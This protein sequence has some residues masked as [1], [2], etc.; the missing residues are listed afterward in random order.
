MLLRREQVHKVV[1]NQLISTALDLQ[2]L[3]TSDKAW[4]WF[5]YNYTDDETSLEK[6][7]VR[8]K[9]CE[10]A[11]QFYEAVQTAIRAVKDNQVSKC[12]PSTLEDCGIEN[13]SSDETQPVVHEVDDEQDDDEEEDDDDDDGDDRYFNKFKIVSTVSKIKNYMNLNTVYI[14]T[15]QN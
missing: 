13:V 4:C 12:L 11:T 7:A 8:F 2:P 3:S 10:L 6:L 9:N 5:G 1:L 14:Y 15:L